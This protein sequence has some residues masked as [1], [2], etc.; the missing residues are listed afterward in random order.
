MAENSP[1]IAKDPKV[2]EESL[3]AGG[4]PGSICGAKLGVCVT[5]YVG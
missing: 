4:L 3:L 5:P 2:L 1:K